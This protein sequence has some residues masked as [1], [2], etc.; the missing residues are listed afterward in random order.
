MG[1]ALLFFDLLA[2]PPDVDI[3][4]ARSHES[5]PPPNI[6]Q[7]LLS[8]EDTS[9]LRGQKVKKLELKRAEL[10]GAPLKGDLARPRIKAQT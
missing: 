2:K 4:G 6:I 1:F 3:Y 10:D 8:A 9:W 7:Q 5:V